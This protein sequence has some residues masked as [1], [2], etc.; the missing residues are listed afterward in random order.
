MELIQH[1]V[2]DHP[3]IDSDRIYV[4]GCSNGGFMTMDLILN[5]P[6]YFAAAFPIC[7]A[8]LDAGIRDEQ[9]KGIQNLPIW[10]VYAHNDT[11]V[12]PGNYAEP[13][14]ARL[15][16]MGANVHVSAF[17]DVHDTSGAFTNEDGSAYQY[18]GHW[19]WIYFF[20]NECVENG[21]NMWQWLSEQS[22]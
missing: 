20:N 9:L 3:D 4:G 12:L 21:V 14:I 17:D 19:S 11:T 5:H 16:A 6:D 22:K 10:F 1:Y 2:E 18:M 7:E 13:T 15:Q 8:Y